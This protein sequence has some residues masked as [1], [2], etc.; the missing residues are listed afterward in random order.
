M[1]D[2]FNY[3]PDDV[4][5]LVAGLIS[6]KGFVDG[7]FVNISKDINSFVAKR[8]PDGTV[9]RIYNN[10]NTYTLR[11]TLH[12]GSESNDLLTKIWQ[13]DQITKGRGKFPIFVKDLSGTDLMFSLT[14]WVESPPDMVKSASVDGRTWVI[15]CTECVINHG[16]NTEPSSILNDIVNIATSALPSL[17]GIL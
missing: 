13:L 14:A 11:V 5:V 4:N 8:T 7:T 9:A 3:C 12:N 6:L 2:P 16:S 17:D 1:A 10:D 15:R